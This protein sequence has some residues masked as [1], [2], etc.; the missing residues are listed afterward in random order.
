MDKKNYSEFEMTFPRESNADLVLMSLLL[1]LYAVL[2]FVCCS[3]YK[4]P[5][6]KPVSPAVER[7]MIEHVKSIEPIDISEQ[8]AINKP[9]VKPE[10]EPEPKPDPAPDYGLSTDDINLIALVTMAEAEGESELGKRLVIDT[11]LNRMDHPNW[12]NTARG[13]IYQKSQFT[14]M[15]NG[16]VNRCYVRDDIVQLVKEEL[17]NRTNSDCVFFRMGRYSDYGKP[18]FKEGCHYFSSYK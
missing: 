2:I 12:P 6:P 4:N 9:E 16:R 7:I 17:L 1:T 18:M 5:P 11:V 15:W 14:S 10:P 13:V 8:I 3:M